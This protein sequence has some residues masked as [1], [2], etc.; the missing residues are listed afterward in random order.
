M[1]WG[2]VERAW[3][4]EDWMVHGIGVLLIGAVAGYWVLE[5]AETH[6][7]PLKQ[8]GRFLGSLVIVVSLLGLVCA[9]WCPRGAHG[10]GKLCPFKPSAEAPA[11]P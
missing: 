1:L 3:T 10:A 7:K 5:R 9:V 2:N 8:I 6:K 11:A 4:Q